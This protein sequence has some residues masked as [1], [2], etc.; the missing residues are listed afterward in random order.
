MTVSHL[1]RQL[2]LEM[3]NEGMFL[4]GMG[5]K[6]LELVRSKKGKVI[7]FIIDEIIIQVLK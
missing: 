4:F 7:L 1:K 3:K 5:F 6:G 2:Y